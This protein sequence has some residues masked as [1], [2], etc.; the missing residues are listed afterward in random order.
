MNN[1]NRLPSSG[2]TS[3]ALQADTVWSKK[4]ATAWFNSHAWLN[5]LKLNPHASVNKQHLAEQYHKHK[6]WWDAAFTFLR[7]KDLATIK[8]GKYEIDGEN[9]Y[10]T[11][12]EG[13]TKEMDATNWES[14]RNYQDIQYL[15]KGQEKIGMAPV[16][17]A[18]V[19]KEYDAAKDL[20]NYNTTGKFYLA[21]PGVFF[22]MFPDDAHRPSVKVEGFNEVKKIVV[23]VRTS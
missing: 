21:K 10:A 23:K 1:T 15:I 13:P 7:E 20:I 14:H 3:S 8:P 9:V 18:T 16:S 5:G 12:T 11:V 19:T 17:S 6:A 22:I 2:H 4:K